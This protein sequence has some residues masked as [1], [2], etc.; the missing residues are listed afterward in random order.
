[1]FHVEQWVTI[2]GHG[3]SRLGIPKGN[4]TKVLFVTI[5]TS[6][7]TQYILSDKDLPVSCTDHPLK[8]CL[9]WEG[10][11]NVIA[12]KNNI[13][14]VNCGLQANYPLALYHKLLDYH[15]TEIFM[16]A[17]TIATVVLIRIYK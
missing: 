15:V 5:P 1:M 16:A 2:L 6:A 11:M 14:G 7:I 10:L 12:E 8:V 13:H 3:L 4:L 17:A 9:R